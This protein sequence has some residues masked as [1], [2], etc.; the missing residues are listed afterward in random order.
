[1]WNWKIYGFVALGVAVSVVL[2]LI[3]AILPRPKE[4]FRDWAVLW[5]KVRPYVATALFS[6]I[7]AALLM[8]WL[9]D[10]L[11][12]WRSALLAGYACDSTLQKLAIAP[13]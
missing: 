13:K 10:T 7:V 3:R 11:T 2:P 1:M 5:D 6:L 8:A 12:T 9:E 4:A